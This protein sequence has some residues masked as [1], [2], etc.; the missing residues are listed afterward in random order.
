MSL[1][2]AIFVVSTLLYA[3]DNLA[4]IFAFPYVF[5]VVLEYLMINNNYH[6]TYALQ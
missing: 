6:C 5:C 3:Q 2:E 4:S 1:L